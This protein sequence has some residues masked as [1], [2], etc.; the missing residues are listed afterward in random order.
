MARDMLDETKV[1]LKYFYNNGQWEEEPNFKIN[2]RDPEPE[3]IEF[4]RGFF[5]FIME[6][7]FV[8]ENTKIWLTSHESTVKAA[9]SN[10][11]NQVLEIDRVKENTVAANIQYDKNKV[12][13]FFDPDILYKLMNY[14][15]KYMEE[16]QL[17]LDK[18]SRIYMDDKGYNRAMVIKLPKDK[19]CKTIDDYSWAMLTEM[20]SRYS[21]KRKELIESGNDK[22]FNADMIGYYNYLISSKRLNKEEKERLNEI[23][24]ILGIS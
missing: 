16:V 3:L 21:K 2:G 9:V 17:T 15:E 1:W 12:K 22:E 13:K 18:L 24:R 20:L 23:K 19:L 5:M 4:L 8:S 7:N 14:P 6:S 10:Y 11:N